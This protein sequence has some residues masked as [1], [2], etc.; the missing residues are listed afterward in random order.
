MPCFTTVNELPVSPERL[1][2]FFT[3]LEYWTLF[4]G[5]G[6]MPGITRATLDRGPWGVGARVRVENTDGSVHH[7]VVQR[8]EPGRAYA[9]K[10]EL[11][12]KAQAVLAA[13]EEEL[14]LEPT[15]G[16]TRLTRTFTTTP[17]AW[18]TAPLAWLVTHVFLRRAVERHDRNAAGQLARSP[19]A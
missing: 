17:R 16:G 5:W 10:M 14:H 13:V 12:P 3:A 9:V 15:P 18:W 1:F 4:E 7:E 19:A 8:Y 6:P 2:S 11:P